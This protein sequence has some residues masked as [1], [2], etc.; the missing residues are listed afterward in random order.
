MAEHDVLSYC[1]AWNQVGF[2]MNSGNTG[3]VGR[4]RLGSHE[5]PIDANLTSIRRVESR[6]YLDECRF[7]GSVFAEQ[8]IDFAAPDLEINVVKGNDPGEKLGD[9]PWRREWARRTPQI[10]PSTVGA[11]C[12]APLIGSSR[13]EIQPAYLF[14]IE[15]SFSFFAAWALHNVCAKVKASM[16]VLWINRGAT[17]SPTRSI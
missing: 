11:L 5:L 12:D 8:G 9:S 15:I 14:S 1:H 17:Q 3:F 4:G 16:M 6:H 10:G 13:I 7:S 2:L